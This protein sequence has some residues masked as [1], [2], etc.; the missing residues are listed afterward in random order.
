MLLC[1]VATFS[2]SSTE[3]TYLNSVNFR[4]PGSPLENDKLELHEFV[5]E[6]R[7]ERKDH[8]TYIEVGTIA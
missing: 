7:E 8:E 6:M 2:I 1:C 4:T 5:S 3:I